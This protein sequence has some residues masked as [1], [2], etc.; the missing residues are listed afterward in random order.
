MALTVGDIVEL[1]KDLAPF[2][3][4]EDWDNVGLQLGDPN[5]PVKKITVALDPSLANIKSAI[6][7]GSDL[8]ITHHPLIFSPLKKLEATD[9]EARRI[10]EAARAGLAIIS[11]HTN[12]DQIPEGVS[13]A[14]G[15]KL[16]LKDL[17]VLA[18]GSKADLCKLVVFVP[19]G[20]EEAVRKSLWTEISGRI[21]HYYHCSFGA[22]GEATFTSPLKARPFRGEPGVLSRIAEWRLEVLLPESEITRV[23]K[24]FRKV[25]PY[26]EIAYDVYP[27]K[28]KS[29]LLGYGCLGELEKPISFEDF[30][31]RVIKALSAPG[32]KALKAK[33]PVRRIAV[34]GGAGSSLIRLAAQKGADCLV[35]GEIKHSEALIAQEIGLSLIDAGHFETERVIISPMVAYL[36]QRFSSS[37]E[38]VEVEK[39]GEESP[40]QYY[41]NEGG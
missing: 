7:T 18:P 12:L 6:Q 41:K 10:L 28:G 34:C 30:C 32:L 33:E 20:Y 8:L 14:L 35:S 26:E 13:F 2:P 4:A 29:P 21:G 39:L 25:H 40:F 22:L 38:A 15:R 36:R 11:L 24:R 37:G 9:P 23:L 27:L 19:K 31:L 17:E 1:V 16:G 3:L 5:K